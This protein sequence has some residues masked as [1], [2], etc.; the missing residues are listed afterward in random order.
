MKENSFVIVAFLKSPDEGMVFDASQWPLHIT[1]IPPFFVDALYDQATFL[2]D[3]EQSTSKTESISFTIGEKTLFGK[4]N[5][6]PVF[7]LQKNAGLERLHNLLL[8][9]LHQRYRV[10]FTEPQFVGENYRPHI[11]IVQQGLY[12]IDHREAVIKMISIVDR[13]P[14]GDSTKRKVIKNIEF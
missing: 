12:A 9:T 6:V 4:N 3:I 13:L 14:S 1:V 8:K 7:T 5:D 2:K 11:T 10:S